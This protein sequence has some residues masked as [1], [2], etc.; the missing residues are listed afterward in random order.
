MSSLDM[1][2]ALMKK[3][4]GEAVKSDAAQTAKE[5]FSKHPDK[6]LVY[7]YIKVGHKAPNN[8]P[9]LVGASDPELM[10]AF[11]D[12]KDA[13]I[14]YLRWDLV[15]NDYIKYAGFTRKLAAGQPEAKVWI[16]K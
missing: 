12:L 5:Y 7:N 1:I 2:K 9:Q 16:I 4:D 11:S 6:A 8:G 14:R 13:T 3:S 15:K 10:Q